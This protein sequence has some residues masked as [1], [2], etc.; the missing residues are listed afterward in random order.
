MPIEW[1][2]KDN[3]AP[4]EMGSNKQ[5]IRR[6]RNPSPCSYNTVEKGQKYGI[7]NAA[8]LDSASLGLRPLRTLCACVID[9]FAKMSLNCLKINATGSL[10]SRWSVDIN[11]LINKNLVDIVYRRL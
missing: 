6:R 2:V 11:Q 9:G 5:R 7:I 8:S 1:A 4:K 3:Y 10:R